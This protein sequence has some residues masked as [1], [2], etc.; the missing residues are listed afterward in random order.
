[1][2]APSSYCRVRLPRFGNLAFLKAATLLTGGLILPETSWAANLTDLGALGD[3][4]TAASRFSRAYWVSADGAVVVGESFTGTRTHAFKYVGNTMTDLGALGDPLTADSRASYVHG[5]SADGLVIIGRSDNG[6]AT[7]A[8]KYVGNTMIDLGALGDPLTADSRASRA[9]GVSADGSV[10]VGRSDTGTATHAFKYVGNTMIDLGALGDPLTADSRFSS[11]LAVSADGSVI[12]GESDTGTAT[13]A[14]KYVGNTMTDLGALGDPLTADSRGSR[15]TGVSADGSVI[16]GESNNGT[17]THAFKYVGNTMIDLGALGDPLTA[18]SRPSR[19]YAISADGSVIVG[20][21]NNGTVARAFKH[22]GNTMTDLGALGDPL[23]AD[24]RPSRALAVSADGSVIVGRSDNGTATHAFK[25]VGNTMT[26]LGALGDPLTA[27]SRYSSALWVSADGSV[28]VGESD[29]GTATHA[30]IYA[31]SVM[32]DAVEWMASIS[33][34]AGILPIAESLSKMPMEGAHHRPLMS[35]DAMGKTSQ[36]W[37]TGDFGSRSRKSDSA[38]TTG[39]AGV[40]GTWGD[41]VAGVAVGYGSQNNDLL[42]GGSSNVAGQYLLGEVDARLADNQSILSLTALIG[43][44]R[45]DT[46]RG[47]ATGTG[48]DY[49]HG[50]TDLNSSSVRL[51]LDGPA[52]NFSVGPALTPFASFT[53]GHASADAY[54]ETGG[55]FDAQFDKQTHNSQEG[56]LGLTAKRVLGANTTLLATAEWIHRFDDSQSGISGTDIDHGALPFSV[57]GAAITRDQARFGFDIDHKLS[58]D[59]LL[60]V[61]MHF[62][63]IGEAPDVSGAISVRRAF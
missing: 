19:A 9:L 18:A 45:S 13:H 44:W 41:V 17:T 22:V 47:Y 49:S 59:T 46:L 27:D 15:A 63:G 54:S 25:Y 33:G 38:T 8:F 26:D 36:A 60:N 40:S 21:S 11:A 56:R 58:A 50:A 61:S 4:L 52:M 42:F 3:P 32:L 53:W 48:T 7:H 24:S 29:T 1:M 16:I 31:N 51:R 43:T 2:Q 10:I 55:S 20:E 57:A 39:E 23:T 34:P 6:T 5:V 37:V 14:F 35:Y 62:T 28:I 30:F 12:V